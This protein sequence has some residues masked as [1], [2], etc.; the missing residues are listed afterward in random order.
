PRDQAP[1]GDHDRLEGEGETP[2]EF[3]LLKFPAGERV[4][5]AATIRPETVFGQT[6]LWVD[7]D[8]TYAQVRVD[9]ETWVLNAAAVEKLR[10]QGRAVELLGRVPGRDLV[11]RE[12]I[13]PG[14]NK[15]LPVLPA[16]FIDQ[17]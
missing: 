1:S 3:T 14:I 12:A 15:A 11:G 10:E 4:L 7:P 5:V 6:N 8:V 17:A 16:E 13:A 2:A 9:G